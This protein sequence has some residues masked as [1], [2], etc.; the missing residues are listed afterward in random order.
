MDQQFHSKFKSIIKKKI[1]RERTLDHL[2]KHIHPY[3]RDKQDYIYEIFYELKCEFICNPNLEDLF[4]KIKNHDYH[5]HHHE[6][7][8]LKKLE[9]E[10]ERFICSPPEIKE[11]LMPCKFCKS[12]KTI[13]YERQTR[14]SDEAMT[15]IIQCTDC[16]KNFK[17]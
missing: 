16:R 2:I 9:E 6:F 15:V 5:Y 14:S 4:E 11:G 13:S 7:D 10:E 17:I 3:Q 1:N 8:S 12:T